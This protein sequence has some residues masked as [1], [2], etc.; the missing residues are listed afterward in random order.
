MT[1]FFP[2]T[3]LAGTTLVALALGW[4]ALADPAPAETT[5]LAC[6]V[7]VTPTRG[8]LQIEGFVQADKDTTGVYQLEVA[9]RG[10]SLS[11]GGP[12]TAEA[13]D[14]TEIGLVTMNGPSAGLEATMTLS[15][16]GTNYRCPNSL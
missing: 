2:G 3:A 10:A 11:Q 14:L 8:L 4:A 1:A 13:G 15:I 6:S 7:S 9:R 12:F 5:G 16:D